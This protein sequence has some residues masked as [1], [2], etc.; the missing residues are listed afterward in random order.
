[1]SVSAK[2]MEVGAKVIAIDCD[3]VVVDIHGMGA[4]SVQVGDVV[5][6]HLLNDECNEDNFYVDAFRVIP[7]D[8]VKAQGMEFDETYYQQLKSQE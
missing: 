2:V 8:E 5:E 7:A 6:G 1:M 3:G 4:E